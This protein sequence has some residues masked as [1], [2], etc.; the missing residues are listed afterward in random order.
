MSN[1]GWC[2]HHQQP[3]A[4]SVLSIWCVVNIPFCH[5]GKK[6]MSSFALTPY[7]RVVAHARDHALIEASCRNRILKNICGMTASQQ[8]TMWMPSH[9]DVMMP[10]GFSRNRWHKT[11]LASFL[12]ATRGKDLTL[13]FERRTPQQKKKKNR[14]FDNKTKNSYK[15]HCNDCVLFNFSFSF[16]HCRDLSTDADSN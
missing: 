11:T 2:H 6:I 10:C 9:C 3:A 7:R 4:S 14:T 13:P 15:M 8:R 16:I 5:I 12:T 1:R